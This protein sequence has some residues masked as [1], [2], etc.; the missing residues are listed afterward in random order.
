MS[1]Q[2]EAL[3][4]EAHWQSLAVARSPRAAEDQGFVD[5]VSVVL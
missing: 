4:A 1:T 3:I 2:R 5:A